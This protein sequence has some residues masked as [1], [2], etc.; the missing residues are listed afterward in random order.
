MKISSDVTQ[1]AVFYYH[2][3]VMVTTTVDMETSLMNKTAVSGI[4]V[5]YLFYG[6]KDINFCFMTLKMRNCLLINL[7][8]NRC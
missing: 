1:A 6:E 7:H 8:K 4:L 3:Y 5:A 2:G